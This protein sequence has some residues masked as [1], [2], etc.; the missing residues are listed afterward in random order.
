MPTTFTFESYAAELQKEADLPRRAVEVIQR[1]VK[2][3]G[4]RAVEAEFSTLT[5]V[6]VDRGNYRRDFRFEKTKDGA[7]M[8]NFAFYAAIIEWG[9]RPGAKM[10][11]IQ[12]IF[13]WVQRKGIGSDFT[14]PIQAATAYGPVRRQV[15]VQDARLAALGHGTRRVRTIRPRSPS[16][17]ALAK[18]A[19][20]KQQWG[21]AL[22]IAR[23]IKAH[24]L[25]AHL[26]LEHAAEHVDAKIREEI[27]K[28]LEGEVPA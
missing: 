22:A 16:R 6:P 21:I 24:G 8:Y 2:L 3:E 10:P 1:V 28:L 27:D 26:I 23:K 17:N 13:E 15:L 5:Q 4:P 20:S 19:V 18:D 12:A 14:G 25:P 11:P 9:R 7:T